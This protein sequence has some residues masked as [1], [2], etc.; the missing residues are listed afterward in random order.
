MA[1]QPREK[2]P[3]AVS[4]YLLPLA[5]EPYAFGLVTPRQRSLEE[6]VETRIASG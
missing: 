2:L 5:M 3:S 4:G 6:Y 1:P